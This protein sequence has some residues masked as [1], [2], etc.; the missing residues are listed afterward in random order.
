MLKE[1]E[2]IYNKYKNYSY[3]DPDFDTYH[4]KSPEEF[5]QNKGGI[6]W[7]YVVA[8]ANELN[9]YNIPYKCY[10][11]VI[12]KWN[13]T[14]ATHTYIIVDDNIWIECSWK[15]YKG[16]HKYTFF[17]DVGELLKKYYK[18]NMIDYTVYNPLETVGMTD[19]Q[20][21]EYLDEYGNRDEC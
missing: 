18:G 21:F 16:I 19:T 12:H 2:R 17:N 4:I 20:F 8:I 11:A 10:F 13:K 15:P 1:I 9:N 6:C 3:I 14:L 7:D 5:D